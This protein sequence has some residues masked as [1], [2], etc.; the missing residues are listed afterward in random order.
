VWFLCIA[1]Q[2]SALHHTEVHTRRKFLVSLAS[3]DRHSLLVA[4]IPLNIGAEY[5]IAFRCPHSQKS[6]GLGSGYRAG[7]L[8]GPLRPIQ[9]S[10]E[11]WFRCC[12]TMRRKWVGAHHAWTTCDVIDEEE[13]V[14]RVLVNHLPKTMIHC[15]CYSDK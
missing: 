9:C 15:T 11:A 8:T 14:P 13:Y 10:Q 1:T 2:H 12:L 6:R 7:Q 3:P 5:I 4:V